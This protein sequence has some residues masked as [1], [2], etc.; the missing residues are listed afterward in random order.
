M[1]HGLKT[2][3]RGGAEN[4]EFL[5]LCASAALRLQNDKLPVSKIVRAS[6]AGRICFFESA[7]NPCFIYG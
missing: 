6:F 7:F 1:K 3:C 5:I 4:P 2:I